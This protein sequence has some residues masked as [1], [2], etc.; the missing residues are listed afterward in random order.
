MI[1]EDVVEFLKKV[2][3]FQFLDDTTLNTIASGASIEFYPKGSVI[4]RKGGPPSEYLHVIKKGGVKISIGANVGEEILVDYRSEGDLIGYLSLFGGD[5]ARA[6]VVAIE[7]TTCYL[8]KGETIKS[9]LD[10]APAMRE[11]FHKSFLSKYLDRTFRDVHTRTPLYGSGDRILFTTPI[12]ELATKELVTA[13]QDISIKEA[14]SIMSEK[15][16]SSIVVLDADDLPAGIVTDRD[17]RDKVV[18]KGRD[19]NEPVKGIMS[20]PLFKADA[21]EYSFEAVLRMIKYNI[22]HLLIIKNGALKGII[23]N[24]DLMLL[25][26]TSPLS[27]V[28]DIE[29]QQT[30]DGLVPLSRRINS[31]VGVLLNEGAKASN[32]ARIISEI[33]DRLVRKILDIAVTKLGPSPVPYCWLA[34]GSEG[35]KEQ[36]FKTDQ[37]NAIIYADVSTS[38]NDEETRRYFSELTEFVRDGLVRCGFPPCPADFMASNPKWCQPLRVWKKYFS[39][40]IATPTS[41]A[42]LNSVI[43]FD[44]RAVYGDIELSEKLQDFLVRMLKD[45]KIFL[46]Y[47]ANMAVKNRPPIGFFKTFVVEKGG[48][49]KDELNLKVKGIAPLVEIVR[50][51]SLEKG[52]RETSTLDRIN[53]LKESHTIVKEYAEELAHSFEVI[54]ILRIRH[55]YEQIKEGKSPDNFINPNN[56]SNLEKKTIKEAFHLLSKVQ[57]MI[58]ER[59]KV[60]IW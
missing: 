18:S 2:P 36:T 54:M 50:L 8:I 35:R 31:I 15:G 22:H 41:D 42:I 56:L 13:S 60:M 38:E 47:I 46:G 17:F 58:I 24:H 12:G 25:Q 10:T 39:Q 20:L 21:K 14:A 49:H 9:F 40:W 7:D 44:F 34:F 5:K 28:K 32:I 52:I 59:Y 37:D 4:L 53:A 29:S 23:T 45:Q 51:F 3:P 19:V 26:G 57:D 30:I 55:Q 48:E 16:I 27:L 43:F 6:D 33:S 1:L 11:F